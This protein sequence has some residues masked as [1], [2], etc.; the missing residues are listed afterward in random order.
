MLEI[1]GQP[2]VTQSDISVA[3]HKLADW[4]LDIGDDPGAARRAEGA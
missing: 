2:N 1:C 4:Q 3:L